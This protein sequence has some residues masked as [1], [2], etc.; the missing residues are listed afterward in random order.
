MGLRK[1]DRLLAYSKGDIILIR[2]VEKGESLLS[3][4]S[5]PSRKKIESIKI[6]RME[7]EKAIEEARKK[8]ED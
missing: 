3:I 5:A 6:S 7:V 1:G 4:L 8:K 2:K